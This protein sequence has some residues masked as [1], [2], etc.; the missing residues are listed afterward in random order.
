MKVGAHIEVSRRLRWADTDATGYLHF[1]RIFEIVEE[2]ESELLRNI[3]WP[4]SIKEAEYDLPRVHV[5]CRFL[6]P[7]I[8][9]SQFRLQ[10]LVERL[11]R[12]SI[13]YK[14]RVLDEHDQLA[15]E[16]SMT[17]VTSQHGKP[18]EIPPALRHALEGYLG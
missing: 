1:P 18:T 4:V 6:K 13:H 14:F 17:V 15:I 12:S 16:G 5:D 9:D 8:H 10:L 7:I 11:G 3:N 2:V